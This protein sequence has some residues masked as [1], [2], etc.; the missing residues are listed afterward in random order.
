MLALWSVGIEIFG[1]PDCDLIAGWPEAD[2]LGM[3]KLLD[4]AATASAIPGW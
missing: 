4:A 2:S 1:E 3:P